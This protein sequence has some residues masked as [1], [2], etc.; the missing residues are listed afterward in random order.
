MSI[1]LVEL[2][3]LPQAEPN[4]QEVDLIRLCGS[5]FLIYGHL[6]PE[7]DWLEGQFAPY[8]YQVVEFHRCTHLVAGG[9]ND[10]AIKNHW[11]HAHGLRAY[12]QCEVLGSPWIAERAN[13]EF[14]DGVDDPTWIKD[15]R[16]FVFA[17]KE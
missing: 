15:R 1:R 16:H 9:P 2:S 13:V 3:D 17:L 11:L 10:E 8:D 14:R 5:V 7:A 6:I 12:M 4:T